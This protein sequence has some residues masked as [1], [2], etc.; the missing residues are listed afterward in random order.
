VEPDASALR[1][2]IEEQHDMASKNE[3]GESDR[4]KRA[5]FDRRTGEVSG[6]GAG[7]GGS[8][9]ATEDYDSDLHSEFAGRKAKG[10]DPPAGS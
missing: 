10:G 9:D 5:S 7:A 3:T 8:P 1:F 4:G 6:S 2:G